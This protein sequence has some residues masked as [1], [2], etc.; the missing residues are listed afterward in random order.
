MSSQAIKFKPNSQYV[1][2]EIREFETQY[3]TTYML[4]D[5]KFNRYFS[6][7]KIAEFI[8]KNKITNGPEVL[9]KVI[10][11]PEKTFT[12]DDKEITYLEMRVLK[13]K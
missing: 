2:T 7:K 1:I 9:F 10:T 6:N 5:D 3:G 11:G 4:I 12:K 8:K 13:A